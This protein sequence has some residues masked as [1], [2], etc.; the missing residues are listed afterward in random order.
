MWFNFSKVL[1]VIWLDFAIQQ[2]LMLYVLL[3]S[4]DVMR[5]KLTIGEILEYWVAVY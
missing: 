4:V 1:G 3:D 5:L 2:N